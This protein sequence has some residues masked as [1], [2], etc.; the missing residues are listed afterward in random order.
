MPDLKWYA[1]CKT[2]LASMMDGYD[3]MVDG[4]ER[5]FEVLTELK[6][7]VDSDVNEQEFLAWLNGQIQRVSRL[8]EVIDTDIQDQI[9][10]FYDRNIRVKHWEEGRFV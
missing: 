5:Y 4:L 6:D 8:K 1:R 9:I 3:Q 7:E 2:E 10:R